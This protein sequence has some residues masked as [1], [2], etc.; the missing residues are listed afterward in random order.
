MADH[1]LNSTPLENL[2]VLCINCNGLI[3]L[4]SRF[5]HQCGFAQ[6]DSNAQTSEE[7]WEILKQVGLFFFLDAII[8]CVVSFI[9]VFHTVGWSIIFNITL[10]I[11][12]VVFFLINWKRCKTLLSWPNFSII[13]LIGYCALA[14]LGSLIVSF[15]VINLNYSLFSKRLSYYALYEPY[16]HGKELTVFF[17]ALMPAVFE[18]LGYRGFLIEKLKALVDKKQ[19]IFISS[20]L[21]AIMHMS[22]ISLFWLL[23]FALLLGFIRIK[24]NTLWY[25]VFMHFGFNFTVCIMDI[26]FFNHYH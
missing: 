20:F 10:A 11:F 14:V 17:V 8:C 1:N 5:C 22:F 9:V 7:K 25:G 23:P 26:Y 19:A 15:I 16:K 12:A 3:N 2:K 21:F 6:T 18:E 24:E 4:E 13:K